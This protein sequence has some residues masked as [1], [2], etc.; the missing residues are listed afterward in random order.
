V[1]IIHFLCIICIIAHAHTILNAF[2]TPSSR[3]E[4]FNFQP[5]SLIFYSIILQPTAELCT[6]CNI[7][8]FLCII[9]I[10][11]HAIF[12]IPSK[13]YEPKIS[14]PCDIVASTEQLKKQNSHDPC[15]L[16]FIELAA[17]FVV[18]I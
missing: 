6:A 11:A 2:Y 14:A 9:S 10:I 18:D 15:D 16:L 7:I 8:H 12:C 5:K 1:Y 4:C 3:P 17:H 13:H